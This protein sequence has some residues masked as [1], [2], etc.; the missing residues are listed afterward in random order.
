MAARVDPRPLAVARVGVGIATAIAVVEGAMFLYEVYGGKIAVPVFNWWPAPTAGPVVLLLVVGLASAVALI[1]GFRAR[2]A[3]AISVAVELA[4]FCWDQ[5]TYSNH[6]SLIVLLLAYL[7]FARSD[8]AWSVS[9]R[10]RPSASVPYW[11][12]ML[13][14]SQL[15]VCY[16]FAALSKISV[17]FLS[18]HVLAT[19]LPWLTSPGLTV[20]L[21][22]LTVL[23]ELFITVGLW[24]PR[25]RRTAAMLGLALH[26]SIV[27]MMAEHI[28]LIAFALACVP[29]YPLYFSRPLSYGSAPCTPEAAV[30]VRTTSASGM[31][32][33]T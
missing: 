26:V 15:S 28:L 31:A 5:Q 13:M 32:R 16:L 20:V 24:I 22:Y 17:V 2:E 6:R 27:T 7:V 19:Q 3:A 11:P 21:A 12:Q 10:R 18:G 9:A 8:A 4:I 25:W 23:T 30:V 14:M 1:A 29:L 33:T